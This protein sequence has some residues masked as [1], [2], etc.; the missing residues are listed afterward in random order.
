MKK[1]T[2]EDDVKAEAATIMLQSGLATVS[3]C[4][5]LRGVSRQAMW[6]ATPFDARDRRKQ[7]LNKLWTDL[8]N[9]LS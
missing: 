1:Q 3:E 8:I 6:N 2:M 7:Y 4:A 9:Q 5:K